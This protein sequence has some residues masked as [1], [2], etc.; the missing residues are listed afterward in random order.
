MFSSRHSKPYSPQAT[1]SVKAPVS[2]L[3]QW[4][5]DCLRQPGHAFELS[6]PRGKPL[7]DMDATLEAAELAPAALLNFRL[8]TM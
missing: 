6:L 5:A 1:F 3:L 8:G 4:V 2:L 7:S